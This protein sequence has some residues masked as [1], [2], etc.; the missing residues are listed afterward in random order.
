M[1]S[2]RSCSASAWTNLAD[3]KGDDDIGD[4]DDP[5]IYALEMVVENVRMVTMIKQ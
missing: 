2:K 3:D 1:I 5:T 4:G